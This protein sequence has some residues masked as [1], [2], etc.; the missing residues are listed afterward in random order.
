MVKKEL[1]ADAIRKEYLGLINQ[2]RISEEKIHQYLVSR[3]ALLPALWP[4]EN[5]VFSKLQL[6]NQHAVDFAHVRHNTPGAT[7]HL[8]EI[9]KPQDPLFT[10]S[11]NPSSKLTHAM[12]QLQDWNTWFLENRGYVLRNFPHT[13][14]M[15]KHGLW[16]PELIL[17]IGRRG[18]VGDRDQKLMQRLSEGGISLM[19]FDS[20]ADKLW[21]PYWDDRQRLLRVC[22]FANG[23]IHGISEM[24]MKVSYTLVTSSKKKSA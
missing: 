5:I 2:K 6:G 1:T 19:T 11:G 10:K 16:R 15:Q 24:R 3:P 22:R 14:F 20:L 4:Y 13:N 21:S 18:A 12:R 8:I 23:K 17:V 9:E 7:W